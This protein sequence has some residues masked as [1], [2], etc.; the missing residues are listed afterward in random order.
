MLDWLRPSCSLVC[1][2]EICQP[3]TIHG[4]VGVPESPRACQPCLRPVGD[5][6]RRA[7]H[8]RSLVKGQRLISFQFS[9]IKLACDCGI[10][11]CSSLAAVAALAAATA[12]A[13]CQSLA[14]STLH[15]GA[16]VQIVAV[17]NSLQVLRPEHQAAQQH[18]G[19]TSALSYNEVRSRPASTHNHQSNGNGNSYKCWIAA[20]IFSCH[21]SE[22]MLLAKVCR[23]DTCKLARLATLSR[24]LHAPQTT[25]QVQQTIH[26]YSCRLCPAPVCT[27]STTIIALTG[28]RKVR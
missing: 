19:L 23:A 5:G 12:A 9:E 26:V 11:C 2:P 14:P 6:C 17:C 20:N 28:S 24:D 16:G 25:S 7:V 3:E 10:H 1:Q 15:C 13:I 22:C 21:G 4:M 27:C 8:V 18:V